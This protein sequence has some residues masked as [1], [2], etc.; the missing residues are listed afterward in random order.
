[1]SED[2]LDTLL[3]RLQAP[4][5]Q[6][7]LIEDDSPS[8]PGSSVDGSASQTLLSLE[9]I[10]L[11][12]LDAKELRDTLRQLHTTGSG[13]KY[14]NLTTSWELPPAY[15]SAITTST[16]DAETY[17]FFHILLAKASHSVAGRDYTTAKQLLTH[18][19][20]RPGTNFLFS[21][22][23]ARLL[24]FQLNLSQLLLEFFLARHRSRKY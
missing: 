1:V 16:T 19:Q 8:S 3:R 21:V 6:H 2:D 15:V 24:S 11:R 14:Y 12:S 7:K 10:L 5:V 17:D 20:V 4:V 22:K 9:N 23:T 13:K 18:I